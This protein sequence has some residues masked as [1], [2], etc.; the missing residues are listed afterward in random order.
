MNTQLVSRVDVKRERVNNEWQVVNIL[1][2]L[3]E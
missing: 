2:L 3:R 1:K